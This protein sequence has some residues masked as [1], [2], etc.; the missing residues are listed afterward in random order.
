MFINIHELRPS[1]FYLR[2]L[3]TVMIK[4]MRNSLHSFVKRHFY[5]KFLFSTFG[6]FFFYQELAKFQQKNLEC[7]VPYNILPYVC[8]TEIF[9]LCYILFLRQSL[10]FQ[11][12][13]IQEN[14]KA[15]RGLKKCMI[16]NSRLI[17]QAKLNLFLMNRSVQ[18]VLEF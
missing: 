3:L 8:F 16:I 18:I 5:Y 13:Y 10:L 15:L 2:E 14:C 9:T 17:F 4:F 12:F 1:N 7:P 6:F 11:T